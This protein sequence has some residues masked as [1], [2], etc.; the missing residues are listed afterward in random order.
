[1][2]DLI[3]DGVGASLIDNIAR[4]GSAGI[5]IIRNEEI[6]QV[7]SSTLDILGMQFEEL[8][9]NHLKILLKMVHHPEQ[10][11]QILKW[12]KKP[13]IREG[14]LLSLINGRNE[15]TSIRV[16]AYPVEEFLILITDRVDDELDWVGPSEFSVLNQIP[17]PIIGLDNNA[18]VNLFNRAAEDLLGIKSSKMMGRS[19][20]SLE[21]Y[22]PFIPEILL[23]TLKSDTNM[24]S[25]PMIVSNVWGKVS[26][27][28]IDTRVIADRKGNTWGA[29]AFMQDVSAYATWQRQYFKRTRLRLISSLAEETADKVRNPLT[30]IKGF[31]QLYENTPEKIP[32]DLLHEEM[33]DIEKAVGDF[34]VLSQNY[35]GNSDHVSLNEVV[36]DIY[37]FLDSMALRNGAWLE[38]YL[39]KN[40]VK[41]N[42]GYDRIKT[43]ITNLVS[44]SLHNIKAG[45]IITIQTSQHDDQ[46]FLIIADNACV[47]S[48]SDSSPDEDIPGFEIALCE[49]IVE[50][51]GGSMTVQVKD[52][53]G[54]I[55]TLT[56]PRFLSL[57][58]NFGP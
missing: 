21:H 42:V 57:R 37:S 25:T 28:V 34:L 8:Y 48:A 27:L 45:G 7:N 3:N 40:N 16:S 13:A 53:E 2:S 58:E 22:L 51:I 17:L 26:D 6:I 14:Y 55:V 33:S 54:T 44:N 24:N 29:I 10:R 11:H 43:L 20:D 49:H 31:L 15:Y 18:R 41:V 9:R 56:I 23:R 1:M 4:S 12:L 19:A 32:W 30:S 46:A 47:P 50:N 5:I 35:R 52:G 36:Q 39:D 38:L